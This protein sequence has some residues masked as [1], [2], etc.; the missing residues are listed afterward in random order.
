MQYANKLRRGQCRIL[1]VVKLMDE[2]LAWRPSIS[3]RLTS[4]SWWSQG[5]KSKTETNTQR[6]KTVRVGVNPKA[7]YRG[8]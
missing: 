5:T 7:S 6:E 3:P 2:T 8:G 4:L 1:K